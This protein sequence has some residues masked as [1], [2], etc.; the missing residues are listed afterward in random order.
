MNES[1][2]PFDSSIDQSPLLIPEDT[3]SSSDDYDYDAPPT[4]HAPTYMSSSTQHT[5]AWHNPYSSTKIY[6]SDLSGYFTTKFLCWLAINNCFITGGSYT[7]LTALSL[8]LFKDLGI[9]ASLN[10]MYM[11]MINLPWAMKPFVGVASD[12]F[13][14]CGYNKR[15][16]ALIGIIIGVAGCCSLL[17]L[18]PDTLN[19]AKEAEWIVLCFAAVSY[20]A[21]ALSSSGDGKYSE[22]I[23][24]HPQSG[25]SI[26]SFN[27]GWYFLGC[28]LAQSF[29]GLLSDKGYFHILYWIVLFLSLIPLLPTLL[30]W[31]PENK[32]VKND[33]GM[34]P[35]CGQFLLFDKGTFQS[36]RVAFLVITLCGLSAPSL[37]VIT[38]YD[39]VSS[40]IC[41]AVV[42]IVLFCGATYF[43]FPKCVSWHSLITSVEY[44]QT[45]NI[46]FL[47]IISLQYFWIVVSI[48]I[49]KL[50]N[51]NI[52][53]ALGYYYTASETCVPDGKSRLLLFVK[54]TLKSAD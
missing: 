39:S 43:V 12:L 44:L 10:Q 30:G 38:T 26:V 50:S 41:F 11:C 23:N 4:Q 24:L 1:Q 18:V 2:G 13:P 15:Y 52:G 8:P 33:P 54:D 27:S 46:L 7:I 19:N 9:D 20:Q 32:R 29:V 25:S 37:M 48:V 45:T 16:S 21:A 5:P 42:L 6:F 40:S 47:F 34:V 31:I 14:I 53:S 35:V 36:K 17:W 49:T 22:L 28:I 51:I 3:S